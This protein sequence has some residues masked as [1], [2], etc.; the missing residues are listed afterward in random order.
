[1]KVDVRD[2]RLDQALRVLKRK[3]QR[4]GIFREM[5]DHEFYRKPSEKK[6]ERLARAVRRRRRV[7]A[8]QRAN[9]GM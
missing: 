7:E 6:K 9:E 5:R 4:E 2:N 3:L 1:M 8:R